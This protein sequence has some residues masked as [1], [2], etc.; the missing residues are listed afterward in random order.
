MWLQRERL[1]AAEVQR[2]KGLGRGMEWVSMGRV[3]GQPR[4]GSS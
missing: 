1:R 2:G 3:E 4:E